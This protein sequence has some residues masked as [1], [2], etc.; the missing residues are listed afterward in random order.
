MQR[1]NILRENIDIFIFSKIKK[2]LKN[3][4]KKN[5]KFHLKNFLMLL[6]FHAFLFVGK[7]RQLTSKRVF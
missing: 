1:R 2:I 5:I 7:Q 3:E 6:K 4:T